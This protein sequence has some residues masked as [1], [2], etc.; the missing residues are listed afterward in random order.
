LAVHYLNVGNIYHRDLKPANILLKK[1]SNGKT[2]LHLSDFGLAKNTRPD[3]TRDT[4]TQNHTKG[5]IEYMAP[6]ILDPPED[7]KPDISKQD[8]WSIGVIAYKLCTQRLPFNRDQTMLTVS[9]MFTKPYIPISQDHYSLD[10]IG[11]IDR[12]LIKD[13][14]QRIS[15]KDLI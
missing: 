8:V 12:L 2:Y 11:L 5:T 10:L 7:K 15:I 3:Y 6:E 1:E 4:T 13:P 14:L 9:A